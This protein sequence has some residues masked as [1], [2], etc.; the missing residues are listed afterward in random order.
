MF[1]TCNVA[2]LS[3]FSL[4]KIRT[5]LRCADL[6]V[7]ICMLCFSYFLITLFSVL[8]VSKYYFTFF[9]FLGAI[10]MLGPRREDCFM[11][12]LVKKCDGA[13]ENSKCLHYE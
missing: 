13:Q 4:N 1:S 8:C 3:Y 2:I 6:C 7:K 12:R 9:F 5:L 10:S 11:F